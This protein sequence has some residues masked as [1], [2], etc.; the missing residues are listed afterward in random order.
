MAT[1]KPAQS[2]FSQ[3]IYKAMPQAM[4]IARA[5]LIASF[6]RVDRVSMASSQR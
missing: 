4:V 2:G 5:V 6:V 1:A 3:S